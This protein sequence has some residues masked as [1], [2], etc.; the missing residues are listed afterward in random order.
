M[1]RPHRAASGD[2]QPM[3]SSESLIE[4]PCEFPLKV[5]GLSGQDFDTLVV[6]IVRRHVTE[7]DDGA[8]RVKPSREGKFVSLTVTVWVETKQQLEGLYTELSGHERV[9]MVL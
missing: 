6:E 2:P 4:F 7:I 5:M 8:V 3:A 9:L 1:V